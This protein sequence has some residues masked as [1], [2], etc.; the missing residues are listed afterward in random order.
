M[1]YWERLAEV[2]T[3]EQLDER[4]DWL[5]EAVTNDVAMHGQRT[6]EGQVYMAASKDKDGDW[7]DGG[8]NYVLNVPADA[9]AE[10]F[11]SITLY[12]VATRCL[13]INEQ[14]IADRSSRMD[15]LKNKDGSI[16]IYMGPDEPK[17][18]EQNWVPTVAGKARF[19]YFR[20]Y[21]PKKAFMDRT[22]ILPDIEKTK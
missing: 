8:V 12:D 15:L 20:F 7:I 2:L 4:A 21:S 10:A 16:D 1:V 18:K 19:P 9:P 17:G 14:K 3:R 22:W 11:W 6:G 5:Y 13:I